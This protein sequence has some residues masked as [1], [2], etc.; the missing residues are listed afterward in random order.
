VASVWLL[1]HKGLISGVLQ[2]LSFWKVHPSPQMNS[3]A[4][5]VWPSGSWSSPWPRPRL[6]LGTFNAAEMFL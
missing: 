1:Y 5:S 4:L 2:R 3:G 6:F